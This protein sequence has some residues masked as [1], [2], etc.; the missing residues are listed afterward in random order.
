MKYLLIFILL[1]TVVS[2]KK[3]VVMDCWECSFASSGIGQTPVI[4]NDTTICLKINEQM[5]LWSDV[6]GTP[7]NSKCNK[8]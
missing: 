8:K 6:N 5:P 3:D 4:P 7:L 2:C 1:S